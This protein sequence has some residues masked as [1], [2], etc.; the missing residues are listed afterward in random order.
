MATLRVLREQ[1]HLTREQLAAMAEVAVSTIYNVEAGRVTPRP[2]ILRRLARALAVSVDDI[3][4]A[5][6]PN[7]TLASSILTRGA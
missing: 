3:Y 5:M 2:A 4:L 6:P 7:T 1:R